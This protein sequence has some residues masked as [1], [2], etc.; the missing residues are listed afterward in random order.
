MSGR[1][2]K[3]TGQ[4]RAKRIYTIVQPAEMA[5]LTRPPSIIQIPLKYGRYS[6]NGRKQLFWGYVCEP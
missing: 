6:A 1:L 4:S 5:C 3:K 2:D